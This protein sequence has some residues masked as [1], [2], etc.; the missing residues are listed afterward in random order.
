MNEKEFDLDFDFEKEYGFDLPLESAEMPMDAEL[1]IDEDFDLDALLAEEFGDDATQYEGEYSADFDYGPD[2]FLETTEEA[3]PGPVFDEESLPLDE[4]LS[5]DMELPLEDELPVI[6]DEVLA[7]EEVPAKPPLLDTVKSY[8]AGIISNI[9]SKFQKPAKG[10]FSRGRTAEQEEQPPREPA[11]NGRRRKPMSPMRKFKNETLPLL[12]LCVTAVLI[13]IFV[14]GSVS[15]AISNARVNKEA[16]K[17]AAESALSAAQKEA[18]EVKQLLAEAKILADGYDYQGAKDLLDTFSGSSSKYPEIDQAK[19]DYEMAKSQLVPYTEVG[20]IANLSFHVLIADP[21]RAFV[22]ADYGNSYQKNFVTT[23][24]FEKILQ[25]L[26]D[27]NYIL[28]DM[29]DV[30]TETTTDGVTTYALAELNL[31]ADKT[32][33]MIT[34]TLVNYFTY[35]VDSDGNGEADAKGAGFAS[36]LVVDSNGDIKAEMVD[37]SGNT[38]TGNYDLVP[39]LEDFIAE[40]PDFSYRG[41]RATLA[42]TGYDGIFG[43]RT[44]SEVIN[45]KGQ[46]YYDEQVA[47]AK[48][49]VDALRAKGYTIACNSYRNKDYG[50]ISADQIQSDLDS[51]NKDV[52]SILGAVD[53]L[54]F[55]QGGDISST[56]NYSGSKYT[57]LKNEG[58]THFIGAGTNPVIETTNEYVRLVRLMV[59]GTQ[60]VNAASTYADF[61]DAASV[62]D[63]ARNT[64]A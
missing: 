64:D 11:E 34:E 6:E 13:L 48:D 22:N 42:I 15:R 45:S 29:D 30:I 18:E 57:V 52:S 58:F 63:T 2:P 37:A 5:L 49:V 62:L 46:A 17:F 19:A 55:A 31:P 7:E 27:N 38:V 24:E 14:F 4:E 10:S 12:I 53:T 3:A 9:Q 41:A 21:A 23:S 1:Q 50:D 51:W 20:S 56:G 8:A 28:V 59:T 35:M 44:N 32:P 47:G 25:N 39:I 26:Y 54:V 43:Y 16:E 40:H 36:R 60:M 61:F 33:I